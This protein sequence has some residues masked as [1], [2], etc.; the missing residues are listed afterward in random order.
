MPTLL[1][2]PHKRLLNYVWG[3]WYNILYNGCAVCVDSVLVLYYL[4]NWISANTAQTG[5]P[6][7]TSSYWN[8]RRCREV[9]ENKSV[10]D[11]SGGFNNN[12]ALYVCN[13]LWKANLVSVKSVPTF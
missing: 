12:S 5:M 9:A 6:N 11:C 8:E 13:P 2:L 10:Y 3:D 4:V 7:L 1:S